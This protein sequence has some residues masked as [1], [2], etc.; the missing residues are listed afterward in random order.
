MGGREFKGMG[1]VEVLCKSFLG[2]INWRVGEAVQFHDVFRG[3]R[4]FWGIGTTYIKSKFLHQ[5]T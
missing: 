3:V 1:L 5:L 2:G 4:A